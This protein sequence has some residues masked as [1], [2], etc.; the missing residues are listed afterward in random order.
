MLIALGNPFHSDS[1]TTV[2][3]GEQ[4]YSVYLLNGF[5][6]AFGDQAGGILLSVFKIDTEFY[7]FD[8]SSVFHSCSDC[9]NF[10]CIGYLE[11][12]GLTALFKID[13]FLIF[14]VTFWLYFFFCWKN[15]C[16]ALQKVQIGGETKCHQ[17]YVTFF[18][19]SENNY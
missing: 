3:G 5:I 19:H 9:K 8:G 15:V 18:I 12:L 10:F 16:S 2:G 6:L 17:H 4:E 13:I 14:N 1:G 7:K 11:L